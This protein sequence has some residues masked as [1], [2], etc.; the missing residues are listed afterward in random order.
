M[1]RAPVVID[2]AFGRKYVLRLLRVCPLLIASCLPAAETVAPVV[3]SANASKLER[4]AAQE[5]SR[6]LTRLYTAASFP[7]AQR[8]PASG[9]RILLGTRA[10]LKT[11][12]SYRITHAGD[13]A[14]VAGADPAGVL[15]GV[16]A[17][18]EKLGCGFYLSYDT[19][20]A[21]RG[22]FS[23]AEWDLRDAPVVGDRMVFNWH[24]FLSS[25]STWELEDWKL[26]LD[27]AA[28][29]RFNGMM[30]HAYGNNPM[31]RF[32]HNGQ[33]KPVGYL[34]ST[35]RG[36]D[37]GTEHVNDVRRLIGGGM[38]SAAAFGSSAA[39]GDEA[40]RSARATKLM[41]SVFEHARARGL[42]VTFALDVD[43]ESANPQNIVRTLPASARIS[44]GKLDLP[45]PDTP[46]GYAYFKAQVTQLLAAYPQIGRLAVWF[47]L[48]N[49]PWRDLTPEQ[50]PAGWRKEYDKLE[51]EW[52]GAKPDRLAGMLAVSKI[53][54]AIGRALRE[55]GHGEVELATGSW[56]L[57]FLGAADKLMPPGVALIPL[58]WSVIF[59]T[60]AGQKQLRAVQSG[61]K[62]IPVVW[63]HHDDRT[64]V[65]RPYTPFVNFTGLLAAAHSSGF[66]IIHW[67]TR[68]LD[69]YFK[70]LARQVWQ[71]TENEPLF[72]TCDRMA[73]DSF[74]P[75][76]RCAGGEYLFAF[77]TEAPMFG[78]ETTDRFMDIALKEPAAIVAKA[79]QRLKLLQRLDARRMTEGERSRLDYF[80]GLETFIAGFAEAHGAWDKTFDLLKAGAP[81]EARKQIA[82]T[83]PDEVIRKYALAAQAGGATRGEQAL[84]ISLNLRWLPYYHVLRQAVGLDP[85]RVKFG[86]T[87]HE[88][89]AQ[90]P[91]HYTFY[92][93]PERRQWL[94]WGAQET[95]APEWRGEA[96][97]E[98]DRSGIRIDKPLTLQLRPIM[99]QALAPGQYRATLRL[100]E[101]SGAPAVR[102]M[103]LAVKDG[104][105]EL[106][107]DERGSVLTA[108]EL[109]PLAASN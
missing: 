101:P 66:G 47:R 34:A 83:K 25:A 14:I 30:V 106:V 109:A 24:N 73:A 10:E 72:E 87:S 80:R 8:E 75:A 1:E 26:Y 107:V 61:R 4:F 99:K 17:L 98:I 102:T 60:A 79:R 28:K 7:V 52:V 45:N 48:N 77:A 40:E 42:K 104:Q 65:G 43:T 97:E 18:L 6:Y 23:F 53:V 94:V 37:W 91:G 5:L 93:D 59:D 85:I 103:T 69:L 29:Q 39:A 35:E 90:S 46:E 92:M 2:L 55:T 62:L 57:E 67:T 105:V 21:P 20:P 71:A 74:G 64:Y 100:L 27:Q 82:G 56:R 9:L 11:A 49:T 95:G 88:A 51:R 33:S 44:T 108:L 76:Q 89:L 13:K 31:F 41:R 96:C 81:G 58:D 84:L 15:N 32:T 63:A 70:S 50:L 12:G 16:Y 22:G 78:R 3:P 68:P 54:A 86:P 38:F 19:M 36:R